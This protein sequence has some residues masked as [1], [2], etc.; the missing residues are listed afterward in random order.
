M[1][2]LLVVVARGEKNLP[3]RGNSILQYLVI[4]N[5]ESLSEGL[6]SE[7]TDLFIEK[8]CEKCKGL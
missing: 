6:S 2:F 5:S 1:C 8:A 7:S 4:A 3:E